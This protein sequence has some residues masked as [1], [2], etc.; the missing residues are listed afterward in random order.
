MAIDF[1]GSYTQDFDTLPTTTQTWQDDVTLTG[2]FSSRTG[3]GSTILPGTGSANTGGLYSFGASGSTE[4]ALGSLGSGNAA[5]GNVSW[6]VAFRNQTGASLSTLYVEY[7]GEQWRFGGTAS[8]Q[9]V[10]VAYGTSAQPG[11]WLNADSLDFTSPIISGS[12][13]ALDGNAVAN[14]TLISGALT[15]LALQPGDTFQIRWSDPDHPGSDH[16]LAIDDFKVS[17]TPFATP[18]P[19]GLTL[20]QSSG[21]TGVVEGGNG[22][23]VSVRLDRQPTADVTVTLAEPAGSSQLVLQPAQLVFTSAN[24][25]IPQTITLSA[26]DDT[27]VEGN[28]ASSLRFTLVSADPAYNGLVVTPLPVAISDNDGAITRIHSIQGSS[29][30]FNPA[31]AGLQT[32]EGVVVAAFPGANG[33]NGFFVQEEDADADADPLT[34]EGI[35]VFDPNGRFGGSVGSKVRVTGDVREFTSGSSGIAGPY[36]SSLTQLYDPSLILDL[37]TVALPAAISVALPVADVTLLERFEGM[38]VQVSA[39]TGE[40]IVTDTFKLGRFGQVGLSAGERLAQ[41]TQINAPSVSGYADYLADILTKSI[42][43][44]DG[45]SRQ[46]PDP[47][48]HSRGAQPL[49]AVNTLRGGDSIGFITGVLDERFEGYRVQTLTPAAFTSTNPRPAA[50]PAVGGDLRVGTFNVLNFFSDLDTNAVVS[51]P[52]GVSFEPRGANSA[53]ELS[54]QREKL[55]T[56][57]LGLNADVLGLVEIENDG[58][59]TLASLVDSL[60]AVAGAGTYA[61]VDDTAL[62]DD[63]NPALNAVGSDAIK[64]AILYKPGAVLPA[65]DARSYAEPDPVNPIFDRPPIAQTF[66]TPTG[67]RFTLVVNH[68]KSKGSSAGRL[69][70]AD[71]R[72]GQGLS[73]ATRVAQSEALLDFVNELR[74]SSGDTDV[75]VLGDLNAYGR[76]DPIKTLTDGGFV[77]LFDDDSYSYQ[78][79]GQW[80]SLD[81]ALATSSLS[82]QVTGATKWHINSDEPVVLDYNTEFKSSAQI[83]SFFNADPFRTSDHDPILIGLN[84][85]PTTLTTPNPMITSGTSFSVDEAN[86]NGLTGPS[87]SA[88]PYITSRNPEV[89]FTSLFTVGDAVNGY[90]MVGIPDGMGAYD[91]GDGSFTLLMNH[92]LANERGI[93]RAHGQAGSFVSR[94]VINK[95]SLQVTSIQDFLPN[96]TSVYLSNNDPGTG[97]AHSAYLAAATTVISR[98]CSADLAPV[99]A[100]QYTDPVSGTVYGT[101]ARLFQSGEEASG[102]VTGVGPEATT[103]FGRQFV[104]VATDDANTPLN[105]NGTAW[106]LPH[107]GLFAWENNVANPFAQRKTIVIGLDDSNGGQLY[108]WVGNKQTSGN[109]VERAGL[110]RQGPDDNLFVVRVPSLT[111]LDGNGVPAENLDGPVTGAFS[112]VNLGDV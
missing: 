46:N 8:A 17:V 90:R 110:T 66:E 55:I 62:I 26:V 36:S 71:Q 95:A 86:S 94:W 70:D 14:R 11:L 88:T 31:F 28:H 21:S 20:L 103:L 76:E 84:L 75:L 107:G 97:T 53:L 18:S 23:D 44:D 37:G 45:S 112:L 50:P 4:R 30:S 2:W 57:I 1:A 51:I 98:L 43:L 87:S 74:T 61:F 100:Y 7:W 93:A 34:S 15:N 6:G 56:A 54:R 52:G 39:S 102:S 78:F 3:T 69:G 16:G 77:N 101:D 80:G 89:Q 5:V 32:I 68:F 35:F 33:L 81:H 106:E 40:L 111:T 24:W 65:G 92:E 48:L 41:F 22:D 85:T 38:R 99:S 104:F 67:G 10:D 82:A 59:A 108:A 73:N 9:T 49:S 83:N 105:E 47:V 79:N 58:P 29:A 96:G 27:A 19:A 13:G 109:V 12:A 42:I 60:N 72:D 64:V 63:P 25:S 91:N